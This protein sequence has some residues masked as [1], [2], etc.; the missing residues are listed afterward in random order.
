[1][2]SRP[3]SNNVR[4]RS[5]IAARDRGA[6]MPFV[7]IAL[8]AIVAFMA[9]SVDITRLAIAT[10]RLQ[11]AADAAAVHAYSFAARN[12]A[13]TFW[14]DGVRTALINANGPAAIAWNQAP[15]GPKADYKDATWNTQ[16]TFSDGDLEFVPNPA[17]ANEFFLRAT[18]RR[19]GDNSLQYLFL[20]LIRSVNAFTGSGPLP[21][22]YGSPYRTAEI[23]AQPAVRVGAGAPKSNTPSPYSFA[24]YATFP[25]AISNTQF[26]SAALPGSG[27]T[28]YRIRLTESNTPAGQAQPPN[29][30]LNAAFVNDSAGQLSGQYYGN[31]SSASLDQLAGLFRY[32]QATTQ[33]N[34]VAPAAVERGS[35]LSAFDPAD[36]TFRARRRELADLLS[37]VPLNTYY[38][39]PVLRTNPAFGNASNEVVGFAWLKLVRTTNPA[40]TDFDIR[41]EVGDSLP[42]RNATTVVPLKVTSG[43]PYPAAPPPVM[44]FVNRVFSLND[45][46]ISIRPRGVV[47]APALSPRSTAPSS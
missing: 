24:R 12:D 20:P 40:R 37:R 31:A 11:F 14:T 44:P 30:Q 36:A 46:S 41:V 45:N 16:V 35:T 47:L 22:R 34:E 21:E 39:F 26:Q 7:A 17:D 2:H 10:S 5:N 15:A 25:L 19:D 29:G 32:F 3:N 27:R 33:A 28:T 6:V 13:D 23:I 18:A 8:P 38:I 1:M 43:A 4:Q 9:C 42:V